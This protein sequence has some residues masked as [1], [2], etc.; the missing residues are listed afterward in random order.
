[1]QTWCDRRGLPLI[2]L[3]VI[4]DTAHESIDPVVLNFVDDLGNPRPLKIAAGVARNP[5]LIPQMMRLKANTKTALDKLGP[6]LKIVL[7][8]IRLK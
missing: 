6:A 4:S 3:R 1:V 5:G 8:T 7:D 2:A